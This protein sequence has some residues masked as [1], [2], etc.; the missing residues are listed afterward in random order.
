M[1]VC[2]ILNLPICGT[3]I[4]LAHYREVLS[5]QGSADLCTF[6]SY[7]IFLFEDMLLF[8]FGPSAGCNST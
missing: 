7:L 1:H 2:V 3:W 8:L 5:C 6:V 4:Y